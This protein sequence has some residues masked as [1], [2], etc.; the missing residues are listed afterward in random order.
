VGLMIYICINSVL[1]STIIIYNNT[2]K[3]SK[4]YLII[5]YTYRYVK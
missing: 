3:L 5:I 1:Y 2:V 4:V